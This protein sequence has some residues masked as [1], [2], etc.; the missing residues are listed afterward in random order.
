[1]NF[2]QYAQMFSLLEAERLLTETTM[3]VSDICMLLG[4]SNRTYF[5]QIFKEKYGLP[6]INHAIPQT[7]SSIFFEHATYFIHNLALTITLVFSAFVFFQKKK[8]SRTILEGFQ[9]FS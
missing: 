9:N 6:K 3:S 5:Y 7:N 4:Y 1:M 8:P 2:I